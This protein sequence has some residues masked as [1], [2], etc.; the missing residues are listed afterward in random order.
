MAVL[1]RLWEMLSIEQQK[2]K[3]EVPEPEPLTKQGDTGKFLNSLD[4]YMMNKKK[5]EIVIR[6]P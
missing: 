5:F 6:A 2:M 1:Q 4:H 3:D